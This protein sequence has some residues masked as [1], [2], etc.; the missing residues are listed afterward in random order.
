VLKE[1]IKGVKQEMK[2]IK[3]DIST[4]RI[5]AFAGLVTLLKMSE[6]VRSLPSGLIPSLVK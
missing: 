4:V 2:E 3:S 1:E 5:V 6:E